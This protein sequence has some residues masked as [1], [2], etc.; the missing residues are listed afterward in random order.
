MLNSGDNE[1]VYKGC[2]E[3]VKKGIAK[4]TINE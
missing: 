2:K 4:F 1:F 3:A